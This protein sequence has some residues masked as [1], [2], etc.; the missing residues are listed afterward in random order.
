MPGIPTV[1]R[2]PLRPNVSHAP[3]VPMDVDT[4]LIE[5]FS[6]IPGL[7]RRRFWNRN[8]ITNWPH[9]RVN[10]YKRWQDTPVPAQLQARVI[11]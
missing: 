3:R 4:P 9:C 8:P 11:R 1:A 6:R 7:T 10:R 2:I 5:A